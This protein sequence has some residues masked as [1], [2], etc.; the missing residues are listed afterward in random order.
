[1]ALRP[2]DVSDLLQSMVEEGELVRVSEE[3]CLEGGVYREGEALVREF[4]A[5]NGSMTAA[6]F[7]D[8]LDTTRKFAIP[9]LEYLDRA[10]VTR[11]LGDVRVPYTMTAG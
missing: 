2:A 8:L 4:L 7:R 1:M 5:R 11:R 3:F 6:Q 9:L 10:R